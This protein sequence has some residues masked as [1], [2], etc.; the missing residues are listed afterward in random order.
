MWKWLPS[1]NTSSSET[2]ALAENVRSFL[3]ITPRAYRKRLSAKRA[4]LKVVERD[5]CG[6]RW[7]QIEYASVPS[8]AALTYKNAFEKHDPQRYGSFI[9]DMR[10][11]RTTIN[12]GTLYPYDIVEKCLAGD[13][14]ETLDVLWR[15]LPNY[16]DG[17]TS[18]GIVVADVSASMSGRPMAVAVSLAMYISER[19]SGAFKDRFITFSQEPSL[20]Q[21][22]GGT[23]LEKVQNLK[24]ADWGWSTDLESVFTLLLDTA[25]RLQLPAGELPDRDYIVSDMEFNE[26]CNAPEA[27]LF[28]TIDAAYQA[29]GYTRPALVFWNVNARNTHCPVRYDQAGTC[30]VSGCSPSI[31]QTLLSGSAMSPVQVMLE[32]INTTRY[33]CVEI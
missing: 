14:S 1:N 6:G 5:M 8:R 25:V 20:Q 28:Q 13:Q 27:T 15:A 32:T 31:L 12:S 16:Q 10:E 3:G 4:E 24:D 21:V 30:L 33:N 23:V 29:A 2:R 7:N 17:E 26:A 18:N 9:E 22:A 11:G 19:N